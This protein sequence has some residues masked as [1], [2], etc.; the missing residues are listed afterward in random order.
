MCLWQDDNFFY[1]VKNEES[2]T[3]Y[4]TFYSITK[5]LYHILTVVLLEFQPSPTYVVLPFVVLNSFFQLEK[6]EIERRR[7]EE[8]R[9]RRPPSPPPAELAAAS[10]TE[11]QIHDSAAR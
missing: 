2:T 4:C 6:H 11:S 1:K 7:E 8:E 5:L 3:C 10:E 9:A